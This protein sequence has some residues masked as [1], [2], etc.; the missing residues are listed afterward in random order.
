MLRITITRFFRLTLRKGSA[1]KFKKTDDELDAYTRSLPAAG[2]APAL[3]LICRP[4][5]IETLLSI[6]GFAAP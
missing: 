1:K 5:H 3:A 2:L 6:P 4:Q